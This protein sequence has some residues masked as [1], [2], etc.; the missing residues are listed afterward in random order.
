MNKE[1]LDQQVIERVKPWALPLRMLRHR[2]AADGQTGV[3]FGQMLKEA[4]EHY[5][6]DYPPVDIEGT[7]LM[8]AMRWAMSG[9]PAP[10]EENV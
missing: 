2:V 10:V 5:K 9:A 3:S 7:I 4:C 8:L 6:V 1:Q